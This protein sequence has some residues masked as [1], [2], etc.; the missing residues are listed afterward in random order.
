MISEKLLKKGSP[1]FTLQGG[2]L[3]IRCH[4]IGPFLNLCL[5]CKLKEK[6]NLSIF[7]QD[8]CLPEYSLLKSYKCS[9]TTDPVF[10]ACVK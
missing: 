2:D 6:K 3:I 8:V 9:C 10:K 1:R 7:Y 5:R 4:V